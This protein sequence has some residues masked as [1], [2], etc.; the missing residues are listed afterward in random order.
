MKK[1]F[2]CPKTEWE[3]FRSIANFMYEFT[4]SNGLIVI[5]AESKLLEE[6]GY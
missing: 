4:I 3:N 5:N 2:L 1:I 6:L